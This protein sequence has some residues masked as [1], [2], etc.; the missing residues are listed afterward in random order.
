MTHKIRPSL[1]FDDQLAEAL[2][3]Y[4]GIFPDFELYESDQLPDDS[5]V[6]TVRYAR[7]RLNGLDFAAFNGGPM[8]KFSE[9]ISF[10]IIVETQDE[11]DHYWN[12]LTDG[13]EES[14]CGWLKD[15]FGVSWQVVPQTLFDLFVDPDPD[16][17]RRA[18]EAMLT[19]QKLDIA[20]LNAAADGTT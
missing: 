11:I 9:A 6:G 5:A 17:A 7:F 16:R 19:M 1:W 10:E 18:I 8:F 13:G 20:A 2:E 4:K 14:Q 12:R 3:F 15:P